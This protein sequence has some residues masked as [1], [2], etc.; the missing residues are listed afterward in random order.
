MYTARVRRPAFDSS[1]EGS[2]PSVGTARYEIWRRTRDR[3]PGGRPATRLLRSGHEIHRE[4]VEA[5]ESPV[6]VAFND[7]L[8]SELTAAAIRRVS[9]AIIDGPADAFEA[10]YTTS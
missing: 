5:H 10:R 4:Y 8:E 3:R 9:G 2:N 6:A 1:Y 7:P